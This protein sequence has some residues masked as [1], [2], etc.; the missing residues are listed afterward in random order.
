[1]IILNQTF[2]MMKIILTFKIMIFLK[3]EL[4]YLNYK[5]KIFFYNLL[6][7]FKKITTYFSNN[8]LNINEF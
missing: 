6:I 5:L 3:C 4:I 7:F 1:M 2:L 8:N